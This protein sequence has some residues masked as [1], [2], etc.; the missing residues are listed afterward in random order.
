MFSAAAVKEN[1]HLKGYIYIILA[2][3]EYVSAATTVMGSYILKLGVRSM[4]IILIATALI[5]LLSLYLITRKLRIITDGVRRFREGD[6]K[7]RIKI[8]ST[9]ELCTLT[10][11][12]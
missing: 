12:F 8:K 3:Q 10:T 5:G 11:A 9:G 1:G 7:S 6:F 2:S 4:L